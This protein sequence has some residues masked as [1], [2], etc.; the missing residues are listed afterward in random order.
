LLLLLAATIRN[1]KLR[2]ESFPSVEG[3]P[4]AEACR[5]NQPAWGQQFQNII[6]VKNLYLFIQAGL[7]GAVLLL[8]TPEHSGSPCLSRQF[9]LATPLRTNPEPASVTARLVFEQQEPIYSNSNTSACERW[10][11]A[12]SSGLLTVS[13]T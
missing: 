2:Y 12:G 6:S 10:L 11:S 3:F 7:V 13:N 8:A 9:G 5:W 4:L 1:I